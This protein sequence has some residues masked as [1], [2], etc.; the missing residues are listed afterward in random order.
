M[1]EDLSSKYKS[2]KKKKRKKKQPALEDTW[3]VESESSQREGQNEAAKKW[4]VIDGQQVNDDAD[5]DDDDGGKA[6]N[7]ST[8]NSEN[9]LHHQ[10]Y[11]G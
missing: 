2:K 8:W 10:P 1:F 5:D 3:S 6:S 7:I 4:A 9:I 11:P